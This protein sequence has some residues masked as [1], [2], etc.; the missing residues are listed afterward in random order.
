[1]KVREGGRV[2]SCAVLVATGLNND[3]HRE[4]LGVRVATSQTAPAWK[5]F[6]ADLLARGLVGVRLVTSDTHPGLIDAT[7]NMPGP[8]WQRCRT[9]YATNL[10][11]VT[12]KSTMARHQSD[13][14]LPC[15][16][17]PTPPPCQRPIR[18]ALGPRPRQTP[19]RL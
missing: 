3:G 12:P 6:F 9:H 11:P 17:S 18:P 8:T 19:H 5:E 2:V 4:V 7:A 10:M 1:M 16:T 13:A 14:A 15:T